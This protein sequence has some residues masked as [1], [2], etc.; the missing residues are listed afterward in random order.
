MDRRATWLPALAAL[1]LAVPLAVAGCGGTSATGGK[2]TSLTVEDYYNINPGMTFW[3]NLLNRCGKAQGV[4]IKRTAVPGAD[5][6]A[7]VLQ[8]ASSRTMPDAL[9]LD[10][11][12]LQ[13]I[14]A[15]G[16]LS[17]LTD[18]GVST[19]GYAKGVVRASTYQ[20]KLYGLQPITNTIALYYNKDM[21]AKA[22]VTPPRTWDE[23]KVDA[24]K[25]TKGKQYGMAFSS[26]NTYE[27]TWQFLPFMWTNG[28]DE[29]HLVSEQNAQALQLWVDLVKD[30][31]ASKSVVNWSQADVNDQFQ[32]GNAAMMVNGPWQQPTLDATA[33]LHYGT[34]QIPTPKAGQTDVSPLG[35]ET[36]TVPQTDKDHQAAAA[37]LVKCVNSDS[38]QLLIA[39]QTQT[40]PTKTSVAQQFATQNPNM[41]TYVDLVPTLRARTGELGAGWPKVATKIYTAMQAAVAGGVPPMKALEQA[42]NG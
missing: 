21:L 25:L 33:G 1:A 26:I 8:Q 14:A 2:V 7:K 40:V 34:V 29:K 19:T 28:G 22:G 15:S 37:K 20:G 11:P 23:L 6:I 27:G 9:M 5:L 24:K 35:G 30:G 41:K 38:N 16:A 31:S 18:Y 36:W 39:K 17:P 42:Q 12:D 3:G 13:Q 32:A 4:T 10:N